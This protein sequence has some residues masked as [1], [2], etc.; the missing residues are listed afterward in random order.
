MFSLIHSPRLHGDITGGRIQM[1]N[2]ELFKVMGGLTHHGF[3]QVFNLQLCRVTGLNLKKNIMSKSDRPRDNLYLKAG[4]DVFCLVAVRLPDRQKR[5]AEALTIL[6][7][8]PYSRIVGNGDASIVDVN[9][10]ELSAWWISITNVATENLLSHDIRHVE[11]PDVL[12]PQV[13]L[14]RGFQTVLQQYPRVG[15]TRG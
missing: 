6:S 1:I 3:V 7:Q 8:H 15:D 10:T 11:A 12:G 13:V 2:T 14:K 4:I 9:P 5:T